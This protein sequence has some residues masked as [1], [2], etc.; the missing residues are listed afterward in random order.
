[1]QTTVQRF[2]VSEDGAITV[3]WVVL[4]AAVVAMAIAATDVING[5]LR[6]LSSNLEAQLRTQQISDAF[7]L[8]TPDHFDALYDAGTLTEAQAE[9]LFAAA[10]EK[11][12]AEILTALEGYIQDIT[13]G[14]ITEAELAEAFAVASVAY[15][16]NIVEDAVIE[17][18]FTFDGTA[19]AETV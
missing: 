16:R 8:F 5:G 1:M 11:T 19:L 17:Y 14:T 10:N 15:Q 6:D 9:D 2:I 4:S 3:D 12:N 7:V 13:D 18:Y